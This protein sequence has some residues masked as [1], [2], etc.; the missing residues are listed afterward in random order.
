M[1]RKGYSPPQVG[2]A[3]DRTPTG[4]VWGYG[5]GYEGNQAEKNAEA[6]LLQKGCKSSGITICSETSYDDSDVMK[7]RDVTYCVTNDPYI[8]A[9]YE[10]AGKEVFPLDELTPEETAKARVATVAPIDGNAASRKQHA[11]AMLSIELEREQMEVERKELEQGKKAIADKAAED[12]SKLKAD[13]EKLQAENKAL[14]DAQ[15]AS[16]KK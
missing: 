8:K 3:L 7:V 4:V 10:K 15:K 16:G 13:F 11:D 14:L 9:D 1:A 6:L 5:W 12:A 2:S